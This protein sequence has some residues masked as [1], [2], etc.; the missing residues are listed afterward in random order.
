[1]IQLWSSSI[2]SFSLL[3]NRLSSQWLLVLKSLMMFQFRKIVLGASTWNFRKLIEPAFQLSILINF[4]VSRWANPLIFLSFSIMRGSSLQGWSWLGSFWKT[5]KFQSIL[6]LLFLRYPGYFWAKQWHRRLVCIWWISVFPIKMLSL[7]KKH[8]HRKIWKPLSLLCR[9]GERLVLSWILRGGWFSSEALS[10]KDE[11][12]RIKNQAIG[13]GRGDCI[14]MEN[15]RPI[16]KGQIGG[17][18]RWLL[19]VTRRNHLKKQIAP[20]LS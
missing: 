17:D 11:N 19:F 16:A 15:L 3:N 10:L 4:H 6:S 13:N 5:Q 1:M 9:E 12:D 18:E 7:A 8:F 20:L 2:F 14:W